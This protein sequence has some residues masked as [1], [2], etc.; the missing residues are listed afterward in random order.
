[1]KRI[2]LFS[3]VLCMAALFFSGC[4]KEKISP[5]QGE[6]IANELKD[7]I[8]KNGVKRVFPV[9]INNPFPNQFPA[10]KGLAWSFSNGFIYVDY[11]PF[12]QGYNLNYLVH[13]AIG[14]V[15]LSNGTSDAALILYMEEL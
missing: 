5:T 11:S 10:N 14:N 13:F 2:I 1:M 7:F 3:T 9:S 8:Q 4:K 12:A 15:S 6:V